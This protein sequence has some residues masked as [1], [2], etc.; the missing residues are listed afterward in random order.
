MADRSSNSSNPILKL[1]DVELGYGPVEVVKGISLKVEE[2]E[3][4]C[5]LGGNGSGKST[6][7]KSIS[8]FIKQAKGEVSFLGEPINEIP[9]HQR[10][11]QGIVYI[12]QDRKL[13][14]KKTVYENLELGCIS[15]EIPRIK[16][17]KKIEEMYE[18]FP[19]LRDRRKSKAESLSG[20]EQQ[21]LALAR[22]IMALSLIHI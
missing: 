16:I 17:G 3:V 7:L 18:Y 15:Q 10:F 19:I 2:G 14:R 20:G 8:G 4:V 11:H 22:A 12:P 21:T 5:I 13:F 1:T 6:V 9:A